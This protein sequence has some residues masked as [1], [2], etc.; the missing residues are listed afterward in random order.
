MLWVR[1]ARRTGTRSPEIGTRDPETQRTEAK[2]AGPKSMGK[3]WRPAA[4]EKR[5]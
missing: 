3:G 1:G 4:R 2:R 5:G